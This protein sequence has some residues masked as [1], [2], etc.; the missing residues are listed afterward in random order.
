MT[1][2]EMFALPEEPTVKLE[3]GGS[4]PDPPSELTDDDFRA[5]LHDLRQ[6]AAG[7]VGQV[8]AIKRKAVNL[9]ATAS[10]ML[11]A[12]ERRDKRK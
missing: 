11:D 1:D 2:A 6:M 5:M 10:Y 7:L 12:W 9:D 4:P 3:N 8:D